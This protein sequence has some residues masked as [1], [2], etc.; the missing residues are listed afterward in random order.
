MISK[1]HQFTHKFGIKKARG[2]KKHKAKNI[3]PAKQF[4]KKSE[5]ATEEPIKAPQSRT[6]SIMYRVDALDM[7][8]IPL[9]HKHWH[10]LGWT[11]IPEPASWHPAPHIRY[12]AMA[13]AYKAGADYIKKENLGQWTE[14]AIQVA[15]NAAYGVK[16]IARRE[17]GI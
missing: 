10:S 13:A 5:A 17:C 16:D 14:A 12:R 9:Q 6:S 4:K 1:R 11:P 15:K 7:L 8:D 2:G 3:Q